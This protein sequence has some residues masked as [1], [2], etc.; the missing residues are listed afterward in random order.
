MSRQG[1]GFGG[2]VPKQGI[3]S[4]TMGQGV[5]QSKGALLT[6]GGA[7]GQGPG[8]SEEPRSH[9]VGVGGGVMKQ[10]D[11]PSGVG[12]GRGQAIDA[13]P[14]GSGGQQ[15]VAPKASG[16]TVGIGGHVA[17]ASHGVGVTQTQAALG[18]QV[19]GS[20]PGS[21]MPR[22]TQLASSM[23]PD[24]ATRIVRKPGAFTTAHLAEPPP[25][26]RQRTERRASH[27]TNRRRGRQP[28]GA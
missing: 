12:H 27:Y 15:P 25:H 10:G 24:D 11:V 5:G 8:H 21:G 18:G 17:A 9:G 6:S 7:S 19:A 2:G 4:S 26:P 23:T 14:V 20:G 22:N 28:W 13:A 1:V 3:G 16:Q